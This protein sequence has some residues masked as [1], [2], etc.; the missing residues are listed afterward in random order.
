MGESHVIVIGL[1][2]LLGGY[3]IGIWGYCLVNGYNVPFMQLFGNT[4]N[5]GAAEGGG[6]PLKPGA[7][8]PAPAAGAAE[9]SAGLIK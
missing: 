3:T 5:G 7:A 8:T 6:I 1:G 4:W 9:G 2:V